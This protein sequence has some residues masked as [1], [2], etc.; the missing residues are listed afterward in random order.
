[1]PLLVLDATV[2]AA[3]PA[4]L[5]AGVSPAGA[6]VFTALVDTGAQKTMVS[7]NVTSRPSLNPIGKIPILT[8]GGNV[9]H[10][11][12]YLFH[13]AFAVQNRAFAASGLSAAPQGLIFTLAKPI[14]GA[15][16]PSTAGSFDVLMG[17]DVIGTGSLKIEGDGTFSWSW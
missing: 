8:A 13:V 1:V 16:I 12:A 3:N 11:N 4:D 15:E 5:L 6:P 2:V 17:I 7:P 10:R 14:W 9:V